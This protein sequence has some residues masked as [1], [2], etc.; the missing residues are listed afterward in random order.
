MKFV[1]FGNGEVFNYK[2][3]KS[4]LDGEEKIICCDGGIRHALEL[5]ITPDFIIGDLDSAKGE[6]IDI[7]KQ[8]N[9]MFLKFPRKKDK[10]DMEIGIEFAI[11][12]GATEIV[13]FGALGGR[14]DHALANV[15]L[16]KVAVDKGIKAYIIDEK[17]II[18]LTDSSIEIQGR[19][20]DLVS[21]LPLTTNVTGVC[22]ENLEYK[23]ENAVLNVGSS[24]GVSNVMT[25]DTAY[26][27]ISDGLL[28]VIKSRD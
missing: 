2:N 24:Y 19:T 14:F 12:E 5:G 10:T 22:T 27:E 25:E 1:I 7:F 26:V 21:L 4:R 20:G 6:Q 11:S 23:L 13:I 18:A 16:L 3:I 17:N 8:K 15:G 28:F 9:V